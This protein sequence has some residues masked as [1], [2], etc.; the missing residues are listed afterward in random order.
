MDAE[1]V[2]AAIAEALIKAGASVED[3]GPTLTAA[4]CIG[5]SD[6]IARLASEASAEEKQ[7]ALAAAA[8]NARLDAIDNGR[9]GVG[10]LAYR[11]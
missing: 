1:R 9:A 4:V 6:V 8:Y 2:H 5:R 10:K 3:A 7:K 11:S